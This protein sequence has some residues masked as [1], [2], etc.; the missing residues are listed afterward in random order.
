MPSFSGTDVV[1]VD[2]L[3]HIHLS[4]VHKPLGAVGAPWCALA[5]GS[6]GWGA[7]PAGAGEPPPEKEAYPARGSGGFSQVS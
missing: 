2:L 7:D 1:S 4:F 3:F 6:V 5:H